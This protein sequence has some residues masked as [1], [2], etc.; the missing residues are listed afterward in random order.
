MNILHLKYAVE[1][2]RTKSISKAAE[3]LYMGQPNLS[4]A[5]KELEESLGITI[6]E[7]TTKGINVTLEGEEFLQYA[8]SIIS[9]VEDVE[10]MYKSGSVRKQKFSACVPRASYISYAMAEFSK[11]IDI[12]RPADIFYK[13]T[14]SMRTIN[15]ILNDA[16]NLG[17]V[18]Y[19][20]AFEKH[21]KSLFSAKKLV[22]ETITEFNYCLIMNKEH[23]LAGK[24]N[25]ELSELSPYIEITHG[26]P[27]VPSMPQVDVKKAEMSEFFD[28][29][30]Y[31]FERASQ[32]LL[33]ESNKNTFMWM[34][35]L[36]QDLLDKYGLVQKKSSAVSRV[37]KDVLI[38]RSDYKLTSLDNIFISEVVN[39]KRK[40]I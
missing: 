21:Y 20:T 6:F 22:N 25:I 19:Q 29:R 8:K 38:Y 14:N 35:P 28:K 26:D 10:A 27:Y 2:S 40:Y 24:E 32:F 34:S 23:P 1:I 30:I 3:N 37:Y 17:I 15:N 13:E 33:L 16:Y 31:V 11:Y 12:D 5:I 36:P 7:R 9:Q 39:A 4:R 18:R